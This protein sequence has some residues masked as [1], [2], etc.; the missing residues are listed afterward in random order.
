MISFTAQITIVTECACAVESTV[1]VVA[2]CIVLTWFR[3][4]RYR[5]WKQ[6]R[7]DITC[8]KFAALPVVQKIF[9]IIGSRIFPGMVVLVVIS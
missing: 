4:T 8:E 7:G 9:A 6:K 2:S 5:I 1:C 3:V